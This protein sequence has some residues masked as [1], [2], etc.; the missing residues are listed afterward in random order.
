MKQTVNMKKMLDKLLF[1]MDVQ[2][3]YLF[4]LFQVRYSREYSTLEMKAKIHNY[5][6]GPRTNFFTTVAT[7]KIIKKII[8]AFENFGLFA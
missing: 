6:C 1:A 7:S 3:I 2:T 4:K 8:F 5:Q